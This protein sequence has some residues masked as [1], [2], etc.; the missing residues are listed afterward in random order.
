M[1]TISNRLLFRSAPIALAWL[2]LLFSIGG[3]S[4][5]A[6]TYNEEDVVSDFTLYARRAFTNDAG[7]VMPAGSPVR[8]SDFAGKIVFMEFF[9]VW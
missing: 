5:R 2:C 6:A 1:K 8:L 7:A 4:A 9:Y 3:L